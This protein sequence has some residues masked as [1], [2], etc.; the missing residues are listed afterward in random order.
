M[1]GIGLFYLDCVPWCHESGSSSE[2]IQL[3]NVL[4][5][6]WY[7]SCI[8]LL[9]LRLISVAKQGTFGNSNRHKINQL[10]K[11]EK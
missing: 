6:C 4:T 1:G 5:Y 9:V 3:F 8:F 2:W 11:E 10:F 7:E